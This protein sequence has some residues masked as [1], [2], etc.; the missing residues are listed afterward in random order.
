MRWFLRESLEEEA[1]EGELAE[2]EIGECVSDIKDERE[3]VRQIS[4]RESNGSTPAT[5]RGDSA[6]ANLKVQSP[7]VAVS[8]PCQ[9]EAS[10]LEYETPIPDQ[11]RQSN[12]ESDNFSIGMPKRFNRSKRSPFG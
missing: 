6:G 10:W 9:V 7:G 12:S 3:I 5:T 2:I 4:K 11:W 8:D 1:E